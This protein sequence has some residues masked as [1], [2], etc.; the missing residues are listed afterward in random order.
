[1][2]VEKIINSFV[3]RFIGT[4]HERDVKAL[5]PVVE[6]INSL[7]PEMQKLSDAQI[8]AKTAELKAEVQSRMEGLEND[9]PDYKRRLQE[10]LE[11]ALVPAF[12]VAREAGRRTLGM[13]HF[14]VQLIGGIVLHGGKI[15]EMK[16][17]EGKTLVAT[18]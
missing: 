10:A 12:A 16:T 2:D 13:R 9:D 7:E 3:A 15:S 6:E 1:M 4:K 18:L 14:D 5:Q 11:P 17:G 8:T